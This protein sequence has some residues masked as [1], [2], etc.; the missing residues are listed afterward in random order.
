[1]N[2]LC[3]EEAEFALLKYKNH[4]EGNEDQ[5]EIFH[6]PNNQAEAKEH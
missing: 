3:R 4:H 1:M 5:D 6:N 2:S